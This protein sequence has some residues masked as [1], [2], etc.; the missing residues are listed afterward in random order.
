MI[1]Q[2]IFF[3]CFLCLILSSCNLFGNKEDGSEPFYKAKIAW[4]S[5]LVSNYYSSH[6][7]DEDALFFYECP[8]GYSTVNIYAL[9]RLDA[10]TGAFIWRSNKIFS[11]II[12]CPPLAIS[13]YIYVFLWPNEILCFDRETGT[14]TAQVRVGVDN[15]DLTLQS[16]AIEYQGFLYMGLWKDGE[17]FVRFNASLIDQKGDPATIQEISPEVLW[18]PE[19]GGYVEAQPIVHKN[20]IYTGTYIY[21]TNF[22]LK[23]P[24]EKKPVELAGFDA[25]SGEMVFHTVF[26][27]PEDIAAN[28]S[29]PEEGDRK[30]PLFIHDGV[31]YYLGV[32]IAAW[33]LASGEI[34][35]RHIFP[36]GTPDHLR[37]RACTLQAVFYQGRVYYTGSE[38]SSERDFRNIHCID[39]KTGEL[40]WN[41]MPKDSGSLDTNPIIAN[42]KL[43]ISLYDGFRVYDP[44]NGKLL[45]VDPSF[46]GTAMGSNILYN[47]YMLCIRKDKDGLNGRLVAVD[48]SK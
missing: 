17:Y 9:T 40:V 44:I 18:V 30:T 11:S 45:G 6:I 37:Y 13:G 12:F 14:L 19:T 16:Y 48:I 33:D 1:K 26:G 22:W 28:A 23:N 35:F 20:I 31:L 41:V 10:Q 8:P 3:M 38:S 36:N 34:L 5:G 24:V 42:G 43:Y 7:V 32:T 29:I 39:A 2:I 15:K 21:P 27:G 46:H 47:D 25:G 4:D